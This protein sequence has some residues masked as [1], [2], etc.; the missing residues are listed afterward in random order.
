MESGDLSNTTIWGAVLAFIAALFGSLTSWWRSSKDDGAQLRADLLKMN[1]SLRA[2]IG[3]LRERIIHMEQELHAKTR[4]ML[5]HEVHL[6][7]IKRVML[8]RHGIDID[9]M[10]EDDPPAAG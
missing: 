4:Q 3:S 2:E 6:A 1:E 9:A 7:R 5:D 10:F 8:T